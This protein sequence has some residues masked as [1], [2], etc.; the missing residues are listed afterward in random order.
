[1]SP[2]VC[3]VLV[4]YN[5]FH[6]TVECIKSLKK[7]SYDNYRI[8][9]VDNGSTVQPDD[10][11]LL[12]IKSN[13]LYIAGGQNLGFSGGNNIGIK[14]SK[15]YN[16]D[17]YLLLNNDTIVEKDFLSILVE[18][19]IMNVDAGIVCGRINFYDNRDRLWFAGGKI[20]FRNIATK[21]C[22]YMDFDSEIYHQNSWVSFATGC[23][24]LVP[25]GTVE[26]VGLLNEDYFLYCE[27]T[28]YCLRVLNFGLKI[29]F[30][31]KSRIY[32]KISASTGNGSDLQNYYM[33]R[34]SYILAERYSK[35][36]TY[37]RVYYILKY[38]K[39]VLQ[40][41]VMFKTFLEAY[42]DYYH[43]RFGERRK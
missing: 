15:E 31:G 1:M 42:T 5:G 18:A 14:H 40:K 22:G 9:V 8:I 41:K 13:S 29:L 34:N 7:I 6:D 10:S 20:D 33:M 32:H 4:N 39:K 43:K 28:D 27:D 19:S 3:I 30:V 26:N 38:I 21:H 36:K 12:F 11:E 35:R 24:W 37:A 17:Y 2:L 25:R 16:P 23:L